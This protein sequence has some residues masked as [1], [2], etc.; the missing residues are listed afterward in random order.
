MPQLNESSQSRTQLA[1]LAGRKAGH[2]AIVIAV[3]VLIW[4]FTNPSG[5]SF[6]PGWVIFIAV[7]D[8][9]VNVGKAAFGDANTRK[10]TREKLEKRYGDA[11]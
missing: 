1:T 2:A 5:G 7:L 3:C 10:K 4:A 11:P 9:L 8:F 6:W